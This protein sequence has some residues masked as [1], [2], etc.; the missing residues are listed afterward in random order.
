MRRRLSSRRRRARSR[1]GCAGVIL[2]EDVEV[3]RDTRLVR[4]LL[5]D[6]LAELG[7]DFDRYLVLLDRVRNWRSASRRAS[8]CSE[9]PFGSG[10]PASSGTIL[11]SVANVFVAVERRDS[12]SSWVARS[13]NWFA[14]F[15]GGGEWRVQG[16][17]NEAGGW[18]LKVVMVTHSERV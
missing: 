12:V 10:V 1:G 11:T 18:D 4:A 15:I 2:A 16:A 5:H 14:L 3:A 6:E 13:P 8:V 7:F 17:E 9:K